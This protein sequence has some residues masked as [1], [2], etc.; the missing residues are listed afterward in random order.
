MWFSWLTRRSTGSL[1]T[2]LKHLQDSLD[3]VLR[4]AY[5]SDDPTLEDGQVGGKHA[6]NIE[7]LLCREVDDGQL[8]AIGKLS[9][10]REASRDLQARFPDDQEPT[11]SRAA[12]AIEDEWKARVDRVNLTLI[13]LTVAWRELWLGHWAAPG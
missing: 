8:R 13:E 3:T 4:R 10:D 6:F 1:E 2:P 7:Y 12:R 5:V 9:I 11:A